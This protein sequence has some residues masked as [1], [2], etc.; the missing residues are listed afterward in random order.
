LEGQLKHHSGIG[1]RIETLSE[2]SEETLDLWDK[3]RFVRQGF[4]TG[5]EAVSYVDL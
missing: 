1:F 3:S 2:P 4:F 5:Q